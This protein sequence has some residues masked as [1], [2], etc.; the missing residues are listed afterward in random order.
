MN[1]AFFKLICKHR[2]IRNHALLSSAINYLKLNQLH[3][4]EIKYDV[5][6]L[7]SCL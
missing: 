6:A 2:D 3:V 5:F 7:Y 4:Y 1:F